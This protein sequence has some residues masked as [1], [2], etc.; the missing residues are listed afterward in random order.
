MALS[1]ANHMGAHRKNRN[2]TLLQ[3]LVATAEQRHIEVRTEKLFR[4]VGYHAKSGRCRLKGRDLIIIDRDAPLA[5]QVEF[6]ASE[7]DEREPKRVS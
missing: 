2:E 3:E 6:L 5:E 1:L 7:L 4:E